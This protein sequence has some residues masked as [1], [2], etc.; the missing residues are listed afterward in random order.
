MSIKELW[1]DT[2]TTGLTEKHGIIQLAGAIFIDGEEKERF[3]FY[4]K[5]FK[6]TDLI[7]EDAL[8]VTGTTREM[9]ETY[10]EPKIVY[11]KLI[12]IFSKYINK[13]D[14]KDLFYIGG[15]NI[16]F[17]INMLN[18]WFKKN[19]DN[20]LFS[21][22]R[23]KLCAFNLACVIRKVGILGLENLDNMKLETICNHLGIEIDAHDALSDVLASKKLYELLESKII[24]G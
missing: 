4:I 23:Y 10:E 19:N 8:K 17:D 22:I 11:D 18:S 9:L 3:N 7:S 5:P 16:E 6:G 20:Y 24:K 15:F 14:K 13:F 21:Y 12:A 2:E 1:I